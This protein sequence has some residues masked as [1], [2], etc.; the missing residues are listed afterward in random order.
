MGFGDA[1]GTAVDRLAFAGLIPAGVAASLLLAADFALGSALDSAP[2]SPHAWIAAALA[3]C[4][5]IVV[6]NVD[7]LRD[8]GIDHASSPLRTAFVERHR[9][10]LWLL[11]AAAGV[12]SLALGLAL[13]L[14]TSMDVVLLCAGVVVVGLLHRR[15]KRWPVAK[16]IYVAG[17]WVAVTAGIPALSAP[18]PATVPWLLAIYAAAIGANLI[19][20]NLP[21]SDSTASLLAGA[22]AIAAVGVLVAAVGPESCQPLAA[23]P[24]AELAVLVFYRKGERYEGVVLDGAL[25]LGAAA[26]QLIQT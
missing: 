19:A 18:E 3:A 10:G 13:A 15:L 26:A 21:D 2:G 11:T 25:L 17:A 23:I 14:A 4:G 6:Y 1:L 9:R 7:R 20:A 5:T 24:A 16:P 8:T 22:R 12:A